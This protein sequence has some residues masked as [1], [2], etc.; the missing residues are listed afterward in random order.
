[1]NHD[2]KV[3]DSVQ[4]TK[5]YK[6]IKSSRDISASF[7]D[8]LWGGTIRALQF[9]PSLLKSFVTFLILQASSNLLQILLLI[10]W[11]FDC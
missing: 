2:E 4:S 6:R 7:L 9:S 3:V 10:C 11:E 8:D 5:H 1:M